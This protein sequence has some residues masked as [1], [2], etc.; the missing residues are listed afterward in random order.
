MKL[1]GLGSLAYCYYA[2]HKETKA[3]LIAIQFSNQTR[4]TAFAI[5]SSGLALTTSHCL[6]DYEATTTEGEFIQVIDYEK[7]NDLALL[8]LPR[9]HTYNYIKLGDS[10]EL[11]SGEE[12]FHY[13]LVIN[14][15]LGCKGYYQG[16]DGVSLFANVE[17]MHG[18]SGGPLVNTKGE[19]VG[20]NRGHI[21]C[22]PERIKLN[23][24]HGGPSRYIPINTAKEFLQKNCTETDKGWVMKS[25]T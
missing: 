16:S 18:Q 1:F 22:S 8:Q 23:P 24:A 12:I 3:T 4:G 6:K 20:V 19:V 7:E 2:H 15:L 9:H 17:M 11:K 10:S 14:S 21:Y 5:S 13:G 25:K